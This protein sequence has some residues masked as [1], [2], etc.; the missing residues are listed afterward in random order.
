MFLFSCISRSYL[1]KFWIRYL[2][3]LTDML[4]V[5]VS[6]IIF[7]VIKHME[8]NFSRKGG[9]K[10]FENNPFNVT[11]LSNTNEVYWRYLATCDMKISLTP[12]W[13]LPQT[14]YLVSGLINENAFLSGQGS[15]CPNVVLIVQ[16]TPQSMSYSPNEDLVLFTMTGVWGL[17]GRE[18]CLV[19]IDDVIM[20]QRGSWSTSYY[21]M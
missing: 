15:L 6:D 21:K 12:F 17:D 3:A 4:N 11:E 19:L 8:R 2:S 13:S 5:L 20:K 18:P 10:R 7:F 1:L 9:K 14:M 16:M